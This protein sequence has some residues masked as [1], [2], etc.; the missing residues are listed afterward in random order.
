MDDEPAPVREGLPFLATLVGAK[1]PRRLPTWLGRIAAGEHL[2]LMMTE[3]R[4]GS[5][6][7]AKH[8][9]Q[10]QPKH[11]SWRTGFAEIVKQHILSADA[12]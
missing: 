2:V 6:A 1:P 10:W 11:P 3:V 4:A 7:K 8:E 9:L 5:N 12:A